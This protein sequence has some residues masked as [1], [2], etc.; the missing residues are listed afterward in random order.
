M[1]SNL[2]ISAIINDL[3]FF[4]MRNLAAD[5]RLDA[6]H[7]LKLWLKESQLLSIIVHFRV[8]SCSLICGLAR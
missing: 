2:T 7:K 5:L 8:S 1:F 4:G 6:Y 3:R